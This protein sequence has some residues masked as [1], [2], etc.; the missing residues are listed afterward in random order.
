MHARREAHSR[1]ELP[2]DQAELVY[3]CLRHDRVL[4]ESELGCSDLRWGDPTGTRI[5]R[6]AA[7][8]IDNRSSWPAAYDWLI[9]C[10]ERFKHE[11][12]GLSWPQCDGHVYPGA[13]ASGDNERAGRGPS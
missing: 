6:Y 8:A 7:A 1:G 11:F 4:I 5:Y 10:A 2:R 13:T 3:E 12:A 9:S